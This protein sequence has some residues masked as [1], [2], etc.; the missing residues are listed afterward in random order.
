M[1]FVYVENE[2]WKLHN[3][4]TPEYALHLSYYLEKYGIFKNTLPDCNSGILVKVLSTPRYCASKHGVQEGRR[5]R[6]LFCHVLERIQLKINWIKKNEY[7]RLWRVIL[8]FY[9]SLCSKEN[10]NI[11]V[12]L[13]SVLT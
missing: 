5:C 10:L 13:R 11:R 9:R 12:S 1:V 6:I 8:L 2:S 4:S 7:E 3:T